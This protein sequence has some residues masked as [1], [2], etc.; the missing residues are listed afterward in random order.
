[1]TLNKKRYLALGFV[2]TWMLV[3]FIF[4]GSFGSSNGSA[5]ETAI[6]SVKP[7]LP[8]LSEQVVKVIVRKSAH[9][10]MYGV[11]GALLANLLRQYSF[12][13]SKVFGY[14]LL[15]VLFYASFDEIHQY[16]V[17]GRSSS[18]RDVA[19]DLSGATIGISIYYCFLKL[20]VKNNGSAGKKVSH[21][22]EK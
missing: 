10:F 18:P 7:Y 11:L 4:S 5:S 16:F 12:N 2:L 21:G 1:M 6:N 22:Q 8:S 19:I 9:I 3:I 14:S 15:L 20:I 17:G 13:R